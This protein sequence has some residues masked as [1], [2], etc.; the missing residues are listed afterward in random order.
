MAPA[1]TAD[2]RSLPLA[3]AVY[4]RWGGLT[5][6][7]LRWTRHGAPRSLADTVSRGVNWNL[8]WPWPR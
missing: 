6:F 8:G 4:E 5:A 2:R 3:L 7:G 1:H